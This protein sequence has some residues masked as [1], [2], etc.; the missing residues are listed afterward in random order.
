MILYSTYLPHAS[1]MVPY[2]VYKE[3]TRLFFKPSET[4][5]VPDLPLFWVEKIDNVWKP[6]NLT[7]KIFI[8][9]VQEDIL[10]HAVE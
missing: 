9:K 8:E 5:K 2:G 3:G 1:V 4:G 7:D 10:Q 6:I